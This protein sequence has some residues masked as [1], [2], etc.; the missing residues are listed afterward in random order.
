MEAK[1][2]SS[3]V[4]NIYTLEGRVPLGKAVP[5]GLQHILAMF[6]ANLAPMLIVGGV[7]GFDSAQKTF[8]IQNCMIVAGIGTLVQL[9]PVWKIGSGLPI[10][11]GVSFTF[12]A[13]AC[14]IAATYGYPAVV[15]A[16]IVG[17]LVEGVLG[18]LAR[19]W[20]KFISPIVASCVVTAIGFSL[21][22][23]GANSFGG[24]VGAP[25]F[26]S[27]QNLILGTVTLITL[28]AVMVLG[29]GYIK[30][31]AVLFGLI[32]GYIVAL[33]MGKVN[34]SAFN[35]ISIISLPHIM[36]I[37]PEFHLTPILSFVLVYLVSATETIGDT[38]ACS[39][40]GLGRQPTDKEIS[41]SLAC[42]GLCSTVSGLFSC[43]PITSFSQN[44]G[45]V[46]M[47]KVVNRFTI[48]TGAI[49]MILAG[50]FP[51]VGAFFATLPDAVLGGCTVIMFGQII[52]SGIDMIIRCGL[53]ERNML[54]ISLSLS[55]GLGFTLVNG[56]FS[57]FPKVVEEELQNNCVAI[58]FIL[59]LVLDY[60]LPRDKNAKPVM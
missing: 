50:L 18:L 13:I 34:F 22:G 4:E 39:D 55:L 26:G 58:V 46:A 9:Y 3:S 47:T 38:T 17:G 19:Y 30:R 49:L 7:A 21:L 45:L 27:A 42:D 24:G 25:D 37:M 44:V 40:M 48:A 15:G 33:F 52:V 43:M 36:P 20:R 2:K 32:V 29:K 12:V 16:V 56:I 14:Y 51:P 1:A 60:V 41:G 6:V 31:L 8:F 35:G 23:V 53:T 57:I 28:L 5:F 10:V 11:M 54:I 59:A